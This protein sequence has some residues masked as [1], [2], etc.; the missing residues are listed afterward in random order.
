MPITTA[1]PDL[2]R[3]I[4]QHARPHAI[5]QVGAGALETTLA[6]CEAM[7]AD[8]SATL[9]LVEPNLYTDPAC[10]AV[11]DALRHHEFDTAVEMIGNPAD[12]ALPDFFF[13]EQVYD[14]AVL[15]PLPTAEQNFIALY[16][17]G[18][19]LPKGALL[20]IADAGGDNVKPWLRR[21]VLTG[22][23]RVQRQPGAREEQPLLEKILR[24]RYQ[25]LPAIVRG[26]IED[27][28][29]PELIT[30]DSDLG[31]SGDFIVLEKLNSGCAV[32]MDVEQMIAEL[33]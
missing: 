9:T 8:D 16:Y 5:V 4:I 25:K 14:L 10:R 11:L 15:N 21:L 3:K 30:P 13:Q 6:L 1:R 26:K 33:V 20:L 28:I 29:K 19:L 23:Y 18:K 31:L 32:E 17:L 22:D 12:Q 27:M 24:N 7:T 2:L